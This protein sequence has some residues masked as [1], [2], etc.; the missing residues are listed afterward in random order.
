MLERPH[1]HLPDG[2]VPLQCL[3]VELGQLVPQQV[4]DQVG[5]IMSLTVEVNKSH[6]SLILIRVLQY[7]EEGP[8]L[9]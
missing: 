6:P 3:I 7:G 5:L 1:L 9:T 2:L 8:N 4:P